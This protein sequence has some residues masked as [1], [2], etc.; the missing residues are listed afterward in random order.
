MKRRADHLIAGIRQYFKQS[1]FS[2]AVL[3]MSGGLDSALTAVLAAKALGPK[4]VTAL[5]IPEHGLTSPKNTADAA[6]LAKQLGIK[7]ITIPLNR[8]LSPFANV[9]W[10]QS[11]LAKMNLRARAR[12]LLLYNYANS[13]GCLVVG[14]GNKTE[15]KLGYFTKYGDGAVDLEPI[16]DLYKCEV[17]TMARLLGVPDRIVDKTPTAELFHG[18]TDELELGMSYDDA[19]ALLMRQARGEP[20]TGKKGARILKIIAMNAHKTQLPPVLE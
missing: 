18:Q 12:A 1:G 6:A 8:F 9:G 4:N 10:K 3:G 20:V 16:G 14:T 15:L 2:H 5:I 13:N 7:A 19:D 11:K 17:R